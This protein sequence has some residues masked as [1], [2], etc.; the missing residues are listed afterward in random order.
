MSVRSRIAVIT[1]ASLIKKSCNFLFV[2]TL[3][4]SSKLNGQKYYS[5][6]VAVGENV[7]MK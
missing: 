6:L 5:Y 7:I 2:L 3:A 1:S 4:F